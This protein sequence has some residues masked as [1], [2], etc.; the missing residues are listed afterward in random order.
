M[1]QGR[2]WL[3][4]A[5]AVGTLFPI[6]HV[7]AASAGAPT[8]D[9]VVAF[10]DTG[11][12]PYHETFRDDSPRTYQHPSTYIPGYPT[13]ALPLHLTFGSDYYESVK[14]DCE[15]VWSNI[16]GEQLYWVPGTRIVGAITFASLGDLDCE[17]AKPGAQGII[18][19]AH[20]HGT[21]VASRGASREY[22]A[23]RQCLIVAV[24]GF[25][26]D[27]LRWAAA[28][29]GW[30]DVQSNSW[31]PSLP[32]WEPTGIGEPIVAN[33][34]LVRAVEETSRSHL[35]FWGSG[36]GALFRLGVL[37]HPTV[38][39]PHLT[40]SPV[41]VGGHDSG[42]V[43]TWPGFS[44]HVVS[45]S[46][47]AWAAEHDQV[48]RSGDTVSAGTSGS[49]PFAAG[50]AAEHLRTA[51]SILGSTGTGVHEGVVARGPA[52]V[53]AEG[54]LADGVFTLA[55]WKRLLFVT[56]T[57]RPERQPEDG[58][59]CGLSRGQYNELPVRWVDVPPEYP[60][61]VQIGYGAADGP[62]KALAAQVLRGEVPAPDRSMTDTYFAA[63]HRVRS[64]MYDVFSN[65]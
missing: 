45:D 58:P 61:Y 40:A 19:D 23:C 21:M 31:G 48:S 22:G 18:L 34:E 30:I 36:N 26:V 60:E 50:V 59:P 49:T 25:E 28:N 43:N 38:L 35:S 11:I 27:S 55:E 44:A 16:D 12:N 37:G 63:D 52:G 42:Y 53:V 64:T 51:R 56:A 32:A 8:A 46:C 14:A 65:P 39:T 10:V 5:M 13:D 9:A 7:R 15:R 20:L 1:K 17:A 62:A 3:A 24:E 2:R 41:I 29:A 57:P 33:P 4:L 54:P 47:N 6:A